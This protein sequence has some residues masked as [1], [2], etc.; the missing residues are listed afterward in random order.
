VLALSPGQTDALALHVDARLD[1]A[2]LRHSYVWRTY[3]PSN[4]SGVFF[5]APEPGPK[6]TALDC[7]NG[8]CNWSE[9]SYAALKSLIENSLGRSDQ[10]LRMIAVLEMPPYVAHEPSAKAWT[11]L[12]KGSEHSADSYFNTLAKMFKEIGCAADGAPYVINS[13]MRRVAQNEVLLDYR[14]EGHPAQEAEVA[15][16]LIDEAKC[17]GARGLSEENKAKLQEIRDRGLLASGPGAA[18][19]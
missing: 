10:A 16:A 7:P 18:A 9:R 8:E 15:A 1:G 19:R 4:T 11:D 6:Y 14:F 3:P 12:A 17:P 5:D 2:S 13:L